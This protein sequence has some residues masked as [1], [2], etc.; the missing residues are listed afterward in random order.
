MQN[1]DQNIR[2]ALSIDMVVDITTIGRRT[3]GPRR[4]EIW[5]HLMD[6]Q[7]FLAASPGPRSWYANLYANPQVTLHLKDDVKADIPVRARPI[8]GEA[9]RRDVFTRLSEQSAFRQGQGLDVETWVRGS[10][11][12]ELVPETD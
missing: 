6:D 9:E 8:T 7:L 3:G 4:I 11:L 5:C 12:V 2:D 1:L 10:K